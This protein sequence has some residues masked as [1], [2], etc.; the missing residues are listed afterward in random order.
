MVERIGYGTPGVPS[1]EKDA[2]FGRVELLVGDVP[3]NGAPADLPCAA[4]AVLPLFAVVGQVG[5]VPT[6]ALALA[7]QDGTVKAIGVLM[8][9]VNLPA[10]KTSTAR[11]HGSGHFNANALVWDASFTTFEQK[12]AA[13]PFGTSNV[14]IGRNPYDPVFTA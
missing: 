7:T 5:N 8:V 9:A 2:G 1:Y 13:F 12:A 4:G 6:G 3:P 10:G 14:L 11:V